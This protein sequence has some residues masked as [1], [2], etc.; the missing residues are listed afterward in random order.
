MTDP[1]PEVVKQV[2]QTFAKATGLTGENLADVKKYFDVFL[3]AAKTVDHA[4]LYGLFPLCLCFLI[5]HEHYRSLSEGGS[6]RVGPIFAKV[7]A[8]TT[9]Y[10]NY[11]RLCRVLL[12]FGA[13]GWMSAD[14]YTSIINGSNATLS[15]AWNNVDIGLT[16]STGLGAFAIAFLSWFLV[17][18]STLFAFV[19]SFL[20]SLE[21]QALSLILLSLGKTALVVSLVPGVTVGKSWARYLAS[22]AAWSTVAGVISNLLRYRGAD[23]GTLLAQ[24]DLGAILKAVAQFV[25]LGIFMLRVPQIT[26][27]LVGAGSSVGAA[28]LGMAAAGA[29][30]WGMARGEQKRLDERKRGKEQEAR[31]KERQSHH[32]GSGGGEG[33]GGEGGGGGGGGGAGG[34]GAVAAQAA[35]RPHKVPGDVLKGGLN[36]IAALPLGPVSRAADAALAGAG[37]A[38]AGAGK[39]ASLAHAAFSDSPEKAERRAAK[40]LGR[41]LPE[42]S[43]GQERA[44]HAGASR[45][46][47]AEAAQL[48]ADLARDPVDQSPAALAQ[49]SRTPSD[50]ESAMLRKAYPDLGFEPGK[51]SRL[52]K[53]I[54]AVLDHYGARFAGWR[55][56]KQGQG[57]FAQAR[58]V[59][60][61]QLAG[62]DVLSHNTGADERD[63]TQEQVPWSR[64]NA[65]ED[66]DRRMR[67]Q[68]DR[69]TTQKRRVAPAAPSGLASD[70]A[71]PDG[72]DSAPRRAVNAHV[73]QRAQG[74]K[75][76]AAPPRVAGPSQR[77]PAPRE[78]DAVAAAPRQAAPYNELELSYAPA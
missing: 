62:R 39:A 10:L 3:G 41:D 60:E 38:A 32:D 63:R 43:P 46:A 7:L 34:G 58:K 59:A 19:A 42:G 78:A 2:F 36:A 49:K 27:Q 44:E 72:Q 8:I 65:P 55:E 28:A 17:V 54:P 13:G 12:M 51:M 45:P 70:R 64:P 1:L 71:A 68:F 74:P 31:A 18:A 11:G 67:G 14:T 29:A 35:Q 61:H 9:L 47:H 73:V 33:G 24:G 20:L 50:S 5:V 26:S 21:Q 6:F 52:E 57:D 16:H 53:R 4:T 25:V 75:P 48:A 22:V 56:G 40:A 77:E 15:T 69:D 30:V 76:E 37:L 66:P 23:I